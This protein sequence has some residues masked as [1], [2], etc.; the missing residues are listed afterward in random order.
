MVKSAV[1]G[2]YVKVLIRILVDQLIKGNKIV[3]FN[4][5]MS[6]HIANLPPHRRLGNVPYKYYRYYNGVYPVIRV[7]ISPRVLYPISIKRR[8]H[9]RVMRIDAFYT[10]LMS[11]MISHRIKEKR[12]A[13]SDKWATILKSNNNG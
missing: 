13:Y 8:V 12:Q 10:P 6:M 4:S 7:A 2:A 3:L 11:R 1:I 5:F 9:N